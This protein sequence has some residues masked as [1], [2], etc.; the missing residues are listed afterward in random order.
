MEEKKGKKIGVLGCGWLGLP[1]AKELVQRGYFVHG[2]TTNSH[3][4]KDIKSVGATPFLVQCEE[5]SHS[6]LEA[7]TNELDTIIIALPPGLRANPLRRF[8]LVIN[9]IIQSLIKTKIQHLIFISSTSVYGE[10]SGTLTEESPLIPT[11]KSGLQL[12]ACET[13]LKKTK[14]FHSTI[15]RF[16]GLIG[17]KRHPIYTL[18][19]R[20]FLHNPK[21]EINLIHLDECLTILLKSIEKNTQTVVYNGVNPSCFSREFYYNRIAEMADLKCPPFTVENDYSRIISSEKVQKELNIEFSVENLLK[22]N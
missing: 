22:L 8:D 19:K 18:T 11:T 12:V 15:I 5:D 17:P 3:K 21:G 1:L 10:Q 13:I 14:A 4:I 9:R 20:P 16:G 6:G 2:S 7:F